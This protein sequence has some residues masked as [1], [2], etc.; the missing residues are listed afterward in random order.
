M[1]LKNKL[2]HIRLKESI[3][4]KVRIICAYKDLSIQDYIAKLISEKVLQYEIEKPRKRKY[5][6][7]ANVKNL[8][9]T[10][11]ARK[12]GDTGK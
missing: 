5:I 4:R 11:G 2:I 3:H 12:D 6:N 7:K 9:R 10:T 8:M 1:D